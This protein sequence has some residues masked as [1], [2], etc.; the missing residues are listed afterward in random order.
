[1]SMEAISH[2]TSLLSPWQQAVFVGTWFGLLHAFDADHLATLGGLAVNDRSLSPTSY[3]LR[4]A[5]GHG[6]ALSAIAL[7]VLGVGAV[8]VTALSPYAETLV[9]LALLAIGTQALR[10]AWQRQRHALAAG[11]ASSHL[12]W[13]FARHAHGYRR[14]AGVAMGL[15][16]GGAGSS[17]VLALLP[18]AH[19]RSGIDS[20]TYILCFSLGVTVGALGFAKAFELC[21]LRSRRRDARFAR[22]LQG[23]V[24]FV[25]I[26]SAALLTMEVIR[27]SG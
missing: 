18:L 23:A 11:P 5:L 19:F 10:A 8:G 17:A 26:A 21:A 7:L 12:H 14:Q 9:C 6:V 27:G 25:A 20:T 24:G 16:H 3:A 1:M 15:V 2:V 4:W 22:R 13:P